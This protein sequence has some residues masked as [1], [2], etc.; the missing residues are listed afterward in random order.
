MLACNDTFA[1]SSAYA[2]SKRDW[3]VH[4]GSSLLST[5]EEAQAEADKVMHF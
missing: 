3:R 4:V 5:V 1:S 2:S